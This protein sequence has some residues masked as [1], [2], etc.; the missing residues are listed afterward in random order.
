M[1][2]LKSEVGL[3]VSGGAAEGAKGGASLTGASERLNR[4][5]TRTPPATATV[6]AMTGFLSTHFA[7]AVC[8]TLCWIPHAVRL[9][10]AFA[11]LA[12]CWRYSVSVRGI[13]IA[14]EASELV[15]FA[16]FITFFC[17]FKRCPFDVSHAGK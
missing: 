10:P 14:P 17:P 5:I 2:A 8:S 6:V 1:S 3:A 4:R 12:C 11:K 16:L 15:C 13:G 7:G 9:N